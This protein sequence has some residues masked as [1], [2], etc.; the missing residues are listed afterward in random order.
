MGVNLDAK[1]AHLYKTFGADYYRRNLK[2]IVKGNSELEK[3]FNNPNEV[4]QIESNAFPEFE[5]YVINSYNK[6]HINTSLL[7]NFPID[8]GANSNYVGNTVNNQNN[9]NINIVQEN[10]IESVKNE[11]QNKEGNN[12]NENMDMKKVMDYSI[13]GMKK[14][15]NFM[16][17]G[18]IKGFG[19]MK[20]YGNIIAKK[21]MPA[22]Q[23]AKKFVKDHVPNF[24]NKKDNNEKKK[25]KKEENKEEEQ[26]HE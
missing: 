14:F 2:S 6:N 7:N 24:N 20:K 5:N 25:K 12:A 15:G 11:E 10:K 4:M 22:I 26:K 9:N 23:G 21:S 3:D 19:L 13:Q 18:G 8:L 1:K 16:K 17:K